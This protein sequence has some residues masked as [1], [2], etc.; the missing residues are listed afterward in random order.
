MS[1]KTYEIRIDSDD[2]IGNW[3]NFTYFFKRELRGYKG[4]YIKSSEIT[5]LFLPFRLNKNDKFYYYKKIVGVP[6]L[7]TLTISNIKIFNGDTLVAHLNSLITTIGDNADVNFS[8]DST[9][10]L[11]S[12][13]V[14]SNLYKP[15]GIEEAE[16]LGKTDTGNYRLG[17]VNEYSIYQ[18]FNYIG[19]QPINLLASKSDFIRS[20]LC[21]YPTET[22]NK[23]M[24]RVLLK[25]PFNK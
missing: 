15:I 9:T 11:I 5:N 1:S 8:Y 16:T 19:V 25:F 3:Q 18:I 2:C 10:A 12:F 24:D 23:F 20:S 4:F 7:R 17:I 22:S 13:N 14:L 21:D 6:T